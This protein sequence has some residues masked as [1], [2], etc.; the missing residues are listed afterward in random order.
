MMATALVALC[1]FGAQAAE[2]KY[3]PGVSDTEIKLGQTMPY[4]GPAS[5]YGI[6]GRAEVAY[7]EMINEQGGVNGRKINLISLD[8]AFSPPKTVE[9]TRKLVEQEN[10]LATFSS[11]GTAAQTAV[12]KYLNAKKV[13]QL[14]VSTGATKWNDPKHFPWT[15]PI[16]HLYSTEGEIYARY[17]LDK[18]PDAK[19]AILVQNDDFGKDFVNGLKH[20]LGDKAK[21][22]IVKEESYELSDPTVDSQI[23]ALQSSGADVLFDASLGRATSQAVRKV[24]DIGWKPLHI[25]VS[26]SVGKPILQAAGLDKAIG[27]VTATPYKSAGSPAWANDPEVK[28]YVEF[29]KKYL[30]NEDP[31]NEI[32]FITWSW[33]QLMV[34]VLER[35]GD[36]LTR[37][38]LLRVA[39]N[40]KNESSPAL[41][42]GITYNTSPT[43]Y[44][45]IKKLRLQRF[46]GADWQPITE[47]GVE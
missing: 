4:S 30:P 5:A 47:V 39:T 36:D 11:V 40:L 9:A 31:S 27:I 15:T 22:M 25:V 41:L 24:A 8:D 33:A 32:G 37:E 14:F 45:P 16:L 12:Q 44:A 1:A 6:E 46:D 43:D 3:G 34:K 26:T 38:N 28:R 23:V 17:I 42:P 35:C 18:K 2:K 19:I 20:G 13:P 7:F 29:M 21:T 10:V